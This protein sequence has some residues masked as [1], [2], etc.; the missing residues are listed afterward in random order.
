MVPLTIRNALGNLAGGGTTLNPTGVT[1]IGNTGTNATLTLAN[2][3][4]ANLQSMNLGLTPGNT[5]NVYVNSG[6]TLNIASNSLS[7]GNLNSGSASLQL[8]DNGLLTTSA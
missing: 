4:A 8:L 6:S 1:N 3:A 7:I 5:S 2:G